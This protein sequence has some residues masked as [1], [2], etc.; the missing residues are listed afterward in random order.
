MSLM[1]VIKDAAIPEH[2]HWHILCVL[3]K[4]FM[5]VAAVATAEFP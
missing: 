2:F 5:F 4:L 3:C 1:S